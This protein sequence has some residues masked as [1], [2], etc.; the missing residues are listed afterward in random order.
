MS[1]RVVFNA[2]P[3][4]LGATLPP[5]GPG[6][7]PAF[8]LRG[9]SLE[10][11]RER[12]GQ[13]VLRI[14]DAAP[15]GLDGPRRF[16]LVEVR[17]DDI[18]PGR[19]PA[20]GTW[21][22][23]TVPDPRHASA[24]E[25]HHLFV[26]GGASLTQFLAGPTELEVDGDDGDERGGAYARMAA[27]DAQVRALDPPALR[28]PSCRIVTYGRLDLHRATRGLYAERRLLVRVTETDVQR[29]AERLVRRA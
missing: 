14:L 16:T 1:A 11:A 25:V 12:V 18:V 13:Y 7:I 6:D 20:M 2:R 15:L 21:H 23:D 24:P 10:R 4:R 28:V 3:L 19:S 29:P 17:V 9:A 8:T 26:T 27:L 5:P 22:I